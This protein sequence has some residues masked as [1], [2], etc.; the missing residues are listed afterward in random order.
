MTEGSRALLYFCAAIQGVPHKICETGD[1]TI[2]S[3]SNKI[4]CINIRT[5]INLHMATSSTVFQDTYLLFTYSMEQRPSWEANRCSAGQEI[6]R[7]LWFITA[8][9]NARNLSL[10]WASSNP[11]FYFLK[12][13]LNIILPF[14]PWSPKWSLSLRFPHQNPIYASS[15]PHTLHM[16]RSSHSSRFYHPTNIGRGVQIIQLLIMLLSPIPVT[17]PT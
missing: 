7:N 4:C 13:I 15:L 9:T 10:S 1:V 2:R 14:T 8:F 3:I 12:I 17:S 5:I 6:P 16:P 11:T